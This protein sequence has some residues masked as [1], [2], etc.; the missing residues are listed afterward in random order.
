MPDLDQILL[1]TKLH[2][3][4]P[5]HELVVRLRLLEW[6]DRG[7]ET[8]LTLVCA[9]AGYGKT[10]LISS[11]L[12]RMSAGE[13][14]GQAFL[15]STWLSLDEEDSDLNLFLHYFIAALQTVF[16]DVCAQTIDLLQAGQPPQAILLATLFNELEE[17]P[18]D[19]ILV[20]DDY[21]LT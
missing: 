6:L 11:W 12:E 13:S 3:P 16:T 20:L 17:L 21:Q 18:R 10:T 8:P 4:R 15:P 1:Q 7:I 5:P 9:P 14:E 2:K 19:T